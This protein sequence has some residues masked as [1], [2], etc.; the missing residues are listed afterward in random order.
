METI[1]NI[2]NIRK[3]ISE[4]NVCL[5]FGAEWCGP[6]RVLESNIEEIERDFK[7]IRFVGVD[8]D[9]VDDDSVL[10]EFKIRNVPVLFFMKDGEIVKKEVGA[11]SK[12]VLSN[13]L[14]ETF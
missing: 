4:G 10:D 8:V 12:E 13:I 5:K 14:K 11:M 6:C 2:E 3:A 7:N 1:S 9:D